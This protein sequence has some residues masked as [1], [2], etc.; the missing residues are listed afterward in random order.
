MYLLISDVVKSKLSSISGVVDRNDII[1]ISDGD[2]TSTC[3]TKE[4]LKL[5]VNGTKKLLG[6]RKENTCSNFAVTKKMFDVKY[7]QGS[8]DYK[9]RAE[10]LLLRFG[11]NTN[12]NRRHMDLNVELSNRG[13]K[14][15]QG[16]SKKLKSEHLH[17]HAVFC[18]FMDKVRGNGAVDVCFLGL[19]IALCVV[20][21]G[22]CATQQNRVKRRR[23]SC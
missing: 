5:H 16:K 19:T 11:G 6:Q 18:E 23:G 22:S 7:G 10:G 15:K 8:E 13:N 20:A 3:T 9:A 12:E 17:N 4:R 1:R 21:C 2:Q 14:S